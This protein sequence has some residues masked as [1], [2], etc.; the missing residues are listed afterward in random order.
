M[1]TIT[2][3][4]RDWT[5]LHLLADGSASKQLASTTEDSFDLTDRLPL[6]V[7]NGLLWER[8]DGKYALTESGYRVLETPV[9]GSGASRI[10]APEHVREAIVERDRQPSREEA[11]FDSVA[12]LQYWGEATE[13]EL[14]A[15]G[16][17]ASPR[18]EIEGF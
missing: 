7:E 18:F 15:D 14:M 3:T 6:L 4:A 10:D 16:S 11:V 9:D 12:F 17:L 5:V 2:L 1:E 13:S 8:D